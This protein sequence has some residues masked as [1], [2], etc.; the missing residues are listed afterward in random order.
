MRSAIAA[1]LLLCAASRSGAAAT[2]TPTPSPSSTPRIAEPAKGVAPAEGVKSVAL[3]AHAPSVPGAVLLAKTVGD[4]LAA[5]GIEVRTGSG[6]VER[7]GATVVDPFAIVRKHVTAASQ[8]YLTLDLPAADAELR[9]AED[10]L[11]PQLAD[12]ESVLWTRRIL[13][14]RA[15]VLMAQDRVDA[16]TEK[17]SALFLLDPEYRADERFLSPLFAPAFDKAAEGAALAPR[18]TVTVRTQPVGAEIYVDGKSQ[19]LA[20]ATLDLRAGQHVVQ[21]TLW[22]H[23]SAGATLRVDPS[24]PGDLTLTLSPLDAA[25]DLRSTARSIATGLLPSGRPQA[26]AFVRTLSQSDAV[27]ILLARPSADGTLLSGEV[28]WDDPRIPPS[29]TPEFRLTSIASANARALASGLEKI[30]SG[31]KPKPVVWKGRYIPPE[32]PDPFTLQLALGRVDNYGTGWRKTDI[33]NRLTGGTLNLTGIFRQQEQEHVAFDWT[34]A[35]GFMNGSVCYGG[36]GP[37][38]CKTVSSNQTFLDVSPR[39]ELRGWGVFGYGGAGF[40]IGNHEMQIQVVPDAP[41]QTD[42]VVVARAFAVAGVGYQITKKVR[43][44]WEEKIATAQGTFPTTITREYNAKHLN[45][46]GIMSQ[47]AITYRF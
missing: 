1:A 36:T 5:S 16:S 12:P 26:A 28:H 10:A 40:G 3:L 6:L 23:G 22:G 7:M 8:R 42:T 35:F 4:V 44:V 47:G 2:P 32:V 46:G 9:A 31:P 21:A 20:P 24:V 37:E 38:N 25:G 27:A 15:V 14:L 45:V 33:P 41:V 11:V 19:G 18:G 39:L 34:F 43:L 17:L 13:E 29:R 30:L